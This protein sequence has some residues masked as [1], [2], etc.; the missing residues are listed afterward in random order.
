MDAI[1]KLSKKLRSEFKEGGFIE[2]RFDPQEIVTN[3]SG[4]LD[5]LK[6]NLPVDARF[7]G[8]VLQSDK[9][10]ICFRFQSVTYEVD[11]VEVKEV[12][13]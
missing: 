2:C 13:L 6:K 5:W 7:R 9:E 12:D 11:T 3:Q 8:G 10:E 1:E 4:V